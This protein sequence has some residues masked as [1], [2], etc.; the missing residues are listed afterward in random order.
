[1]PPKENDK[2]SA[3]QVAYIKDWIAGGAPWPDAKRITALLKQE[4]PWVV[5]GGCAG[6]DQW[7]FERGLDQSEI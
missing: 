2:L 4:D 5:E 3:E 7:W 1:M 6:P